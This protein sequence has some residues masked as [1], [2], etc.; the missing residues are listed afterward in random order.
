MNPHEPDRPQLGTLAEQQ[1]QALEDLAHARMVAD[2]CGNSPAA[3]DAVARL[4]RRVAII[5]ARM[6]VT[7]DLSRPGEP[8]S[9]EAD[10]QTQ[11]EADG[12]EGSQ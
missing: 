7:H 5:T 6:P 11:D 12:K 4:E 10:Q 1:R 3:R 9:L 2:A 8:V